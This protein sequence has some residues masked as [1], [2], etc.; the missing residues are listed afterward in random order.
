MTFLVR[1]LAR[2]RDN[3]QLGCGRLQP[4]ETQ[5]KSSLRKSL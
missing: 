5:I 3:R 4:R 1:L 2:L